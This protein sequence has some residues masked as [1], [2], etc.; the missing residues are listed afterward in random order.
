MF[1]KSLVSQ[2]K[3]LCV[4]LIMILGLY[5]MSSAYAQN[6]Q[7]LVRSLS[8]LL[9]FLDDDNIELKMEPG[10]YVI[11]PDDVKKGSFGITDFED[12]AKVLLLFSG[13][14]S[15]YDFTGVT[16]Q[17][18]T[19]VFKSFGNYRV[20]ELVVTGSNNVLKNLTM[21]D[22][23]SEYDKP[24]KGA[25]GVC[26]DGRDNRIEGFHMT[27]KGSFPYGYGDAFGKGK[28]NVIRHQ[29]H[30]AFLIRGLRNHA[31]NCTIIHH[32][33]GHAIFMQAAS[34]PTIE[35]CVVEGRMR[36]TDDMLA[37]TSGPAFDV[38]FMT[39]WGYKLPPGYMLSLGEAGIRAYDGGTTI[40]DGEVFKRGT[41]NPTI[42]NCTVKNMRTG[43][44]I[45][46]AK[47]KKYV[48]G[49]VVIGCENGYS[50]GAGEVV[51]CKADCAY[52]PVYAS[53]YERDKGYH[54][55][56]TIIPAE[57]GYYNGSGS[58]AYIGGT[59]HKITLRGTPE[60]VEEGLKIKVGGEKGNIRL[61]HGNFPHQNN[62]KA[63]D[64]EL[65]N[66]SGFPVVL[67]E[68]SANVH[69]YSVGGVEDHGVR[70]MVKKAK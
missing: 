31:K 8:E 21:V 10:T 40:V 62:F 53:T 65:N 19:G 3:V 44:T 11:T 69:V 41:D 34:Y 29:K 42:L 27:V 7:V 5:K 46:H 58:V 16:L 56:I 47:G 24:N 39:A 50:L 67:S 61:M 18:E 6:S 36:K 25:L 54:A 28:H 38:D 37:E 23:G 20:H 32:S 57:N 30:S 1:D 55:D 4:A 43:V 70:N 48:E 52:G 60:L 12:R 51:N 15:S 63:S 35:G 14:N 33:Y 22:V 2:R 17:I 64:F 59:G 13:N 26:M 68:K 45:A 66:L 49:C 9:P